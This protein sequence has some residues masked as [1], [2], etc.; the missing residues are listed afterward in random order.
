M[1]KIIRIVIALAVFQSLLLLVSYFYYGFCTTKYGRCVIPVSILNYYWLVIF[2]DYIT[3]VVF[4]HIQK[5]FQSLLLLV[6]YFYYLKR[7]KLNLGEVNWFQSLL[8]LV[9]YFYS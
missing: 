9:S 7:E 8:L 3:E 4:D 1:G 5:E 2:T 6:S